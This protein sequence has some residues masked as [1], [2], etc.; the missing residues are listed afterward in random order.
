[1]IEGFY[2]Y[3]RNN[4]NNYKFNFKK[5][6]LKGKG[7]LNYKADESKLFAGL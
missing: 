7:T 1:M 6:K 4:Q 3:K 2:T 5:Y